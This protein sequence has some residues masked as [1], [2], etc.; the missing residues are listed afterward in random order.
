[1]GHNPPMTTNTTMKMKCLKCGVSK[2]EL[3]DNPFEIHH[4]SNKYKMEEIYMILYV[5]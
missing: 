4:I 3:S 1:M 2:Y 5:L